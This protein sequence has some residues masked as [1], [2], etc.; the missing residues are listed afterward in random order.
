MTPWEVSGSDGSDTLVDVDWY[1]PG[2]EDLFLFGDP[3]DC[4]PEEE[5]ELLELLPKEVDC[6]FPEEAD[7]FPEDLDLYFPE[8]AD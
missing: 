6:S 4:L 7:P 1:L 5:A 2:L 8:E 3:R